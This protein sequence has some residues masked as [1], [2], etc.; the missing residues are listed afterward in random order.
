VVRS[1]AFY[2][3]QFH[4]IPEN[5][6]WWG[7]GFTD[8][9]NVRKGK[10]RFRGHHQPHVPTELGYYDLRDAEVRQAQADMAAAYGI[11]GFCYYHYW[12]HGRRLL[13]E[14]FDAVLESGKPDFPFMLCWA[15]ENWTRTWSGQNDQ[16]LIRQEY[17]DEDHR[18]HIRWLATAFADDRYIRVDG[19][20]LFLVY[21]AAALRPTPKRVADIWREEASRLGVGDLF[22]ACVDYGVSRPDPRDLGLDA[23]VE[24]HPDGPLRQRPRWFRAGRRLTRSAGP[25]RHSVL[26]YDQY[27]R[28]A[29]D[30][31]DPAYRRFPCVTPGWDN[32]VRRR[33][34]AF[35]LRDST[36]TEFE[37]W[38]RTI[39]NREAGESGDRLVFVNGW[40]EWA[41]GNHLEPCERWG[42]EYLEAHKRAKA[43]VASSAGHELPQR[44]AAGFAE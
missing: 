18:N 35:I 38:M 9:T 10:P 25:F 13:N 19:K 28:R 41:E 17:S 1:I 15:N 16:V 39:L 11:D 24:F 14:P 40:N 4:P 2:F 33:K 44:G 7:E 8:W 3:P 29:I 30:R 5:D 21:R 43:A 26:G 32:S 20:P 23:A 37:M 12:F 27:A 6:E 22:L 31:A 34:E 42:Y 36:P